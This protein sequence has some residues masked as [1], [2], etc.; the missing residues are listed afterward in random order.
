M[1]NEFPSPINDVMICD[2]PVRLGV[3]IGVLEFYQDWVY[4]KSR[5]NLLGT[6]VVAGYLR[7]EN[8][9]AYLQTISSRRAV[10]H[11]SDEALLLCMYEEMTFRQRRQ[12]DIWLIIVANVIIFNIFIR[13]VFGVILRSPHVIW[14]VLVRANTSLSYSSGTVLA[15]G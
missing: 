14:V 1:H 6:T 4:K 9:S 5:E 2:I 12:Q 3:I 7:I 15:T 8:L 11:H 13:Q 10:F